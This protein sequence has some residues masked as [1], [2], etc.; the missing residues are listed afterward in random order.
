LS[1]ALF[2]CSINFTP[3]SLVLA[4]VSLTSP[5]GPFAIGVAAAGVAAALCFDVSSFRLEE[6]GADGGGSYMVGREK[7][8]LRIL[9][10][11]FAMRT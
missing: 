6:G 1:L 7:C 4:G 3:T 5:G 11:D 9:F 10:I 8:Q 2:I